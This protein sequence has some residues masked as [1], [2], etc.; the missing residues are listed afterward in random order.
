MSERERVTKPGAPDERD[1]DPP[2]K[3][4]RALCAAADP[5]VRPSEALR[6]RVAGLAAVHD[7]RAV[8]RRIRSPLRPRWRSA[9]GAAAAVV[10]LTLLGLAI[11]QWVGVYSSSEHR[12]KEPAGGFTASPGSIVSIPLPPLLL[13]PP[14][15]TSGGTPFDK[16]D[17]A[18][19]DS[20]RKEREP[21]PAGAAQPAGQ[22][23]R[24]QPAP[25]SAAHPEA[26]RGDDLVYL[27]LNP[28]ETL[29]QWAPLPPDERSRIEAQIKRRV[30]GR[31]DFIRIPFPRIASAAERQIAEA[32]EQYKKEAAVVD[33]RLFRKVTLQEKAVSFDNFCRVLEQQTGVRIE[34]GRTVA[35]EKVTAFVRERPLRDLMREVSRLFGFTWLRTRQATGDRRQATGESPVGSD[36]Q[37]LTPDASFRY[38]L[39]QDLRSQLLEEEL[40]N[41]DH[42]ESLLVMDQQLQA[43]RPYR[44]LTPEELRAKAEAATSPELKKQLQL[45]AGLGWGPFQ[46]YFRLSPDEMATLRSGNSLRFSSQPGPNDRPLPDDFRLTVLGAFSNYRIWQKGASHGFG[47]ESSVPAGAD[48]YE[49]KAYPE[50]GATVALSISRSELGQIQLMGSSGFSAGGGGMSAPALLATAVSPS[51]ASPENARANAGLAHDPAMQPLVSWRP[52]SS[53]HGGGDYPASYSVSREDAS[54]ARQRMGEEVAQSDPDAVPV[55]TADLLAA[56]HRATG[57]DIL[58]DAY[59]RF[60]PPAA[61]SVEKSRLFDALNRVADTMRYRWHKEDDFLLFRSASYF[62]DQLKEVPNRLLDRWAASLRQNDH[63]TLDDLVEIAGLTDAQLDSELIA[64]GA[65]RCHG[66]KGWNLARSPNLRKHLRFLALLDPG[67]RR[68]AQSQ[69]GLPFPRMTNS[70]QQQFLSI[71]FGSWNTPIAP[72]TLPGARLRAAL[73][74]PGQFEWVPAAE[75]DDFPSDRRVRAATREQAL[76]AARRLDSRVSAGDLLPT[77][78]DLS[79]EYTLGPGAD[80]STPFALIQSNGARSG[81]R[82]AGAPLLPAHKLAER[83]DGGDARARAPVCRPVPTR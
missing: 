82:H 57:I 42:N 52:G 39:E 66:I 9:A 33:A 12:S 5:P 27:N 40:R 59:T 50:A 48:Q 37:R 61:V 68:L 71:A 18:V 16:G 43:L 79:I 80:G 72:E 83:V 2:G 65:V 23:P 76:A 69:E 62:N 3:R 47:P 26:L 25:L 38:E 8:R 21:S 22:G 31:D 10:L 20:R 15:R 77:V 73:S 11:R 36:A 41:R 24:R 14:A 63:L 78:A 55:S 35:D 7:A 13:A 67:Q 70:Q 1:L 4:L 32:A 53:C 58:S 64:A 51:V 34:A 44:G 74:W 29:R 56:I 46:L 6:R 45:L 19:P 81:Y 28:E 60:Y 49:P 17:R 54:A 75:W 30:R